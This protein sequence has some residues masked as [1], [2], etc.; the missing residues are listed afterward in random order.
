MNSDS[1]LA[2]I[3]ILIIVLAAIA[4]VGLKRPVVAKLVLAMGAFLLTGVS[5]VLGNDTVPAW[6]LALAGLLI[7]ADVWLSHKRQK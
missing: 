3:F 4:R 2:I 6:I 7:M 5:Y 1:A